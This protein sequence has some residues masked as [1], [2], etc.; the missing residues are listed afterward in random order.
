MA[1]VGYCKALGYVPVNI[2]LKT[3]EG[4]QREQK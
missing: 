1:G 2:Q 4:K 3:L